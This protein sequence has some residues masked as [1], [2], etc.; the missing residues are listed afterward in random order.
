MTGVV[1]VKVIR[2]SCFTTEVRGW[3]KHLLGNSNNS[4]D[5]GGESVLTGYGVSS[6]V[7]D[8]L[9]DQAKGQST[10][11]ACF[12]FD[13]AARKEHSAASMLSSLLKQVV[14]GWKI[15]HQKYQRPFEN[16]KR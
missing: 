13:F 5:K 12:Y 2:Q 6:L 1:E 4:L 16:R 14:G 15:F 9:C 11:V 7:V 8:W 3:A 10:A